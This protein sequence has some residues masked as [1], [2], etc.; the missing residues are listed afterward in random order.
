MVLLQIIV[1]KCGNILDSINSALTNL[2]SAVIINM[3]TAYLEEYLIPFFIFKPFK[4]WSGQVCK[5]TAGLR[6]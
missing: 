6:Q 1:A 2:S 5:I 4:D 3:K